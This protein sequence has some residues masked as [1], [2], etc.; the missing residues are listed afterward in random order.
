M[1]VY[2]IK[3]VREFKGVLGF[4]LKGDLW[5][6]VFQGEKKGDLLMEDRTPD[7]QKPT[8]LS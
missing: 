4:A 8:Q 7:S 3:E 6:I 1:P 2:S 5:Y